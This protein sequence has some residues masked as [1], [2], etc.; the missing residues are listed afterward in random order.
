MLQNFINKYFRHNSK[1]FKNYLA[2]LSG[3]ILFLAFAPISFYPLAIIANTVLF[4]LW[5]VALNKKDALRYGWLFGCGLFSFGA[6]WIY[7]SLHTYGFMPVPIALI[8]T[9]LFIGFLALFPALQ[10]ILYFKILDI[11]RKYLLKP[12]LQHSLIVNKLSDIKLDILNVFILFPF[13]YVFFEWLRSWLFTGFPW[14]FLGYS[15]IDS[16]LRGFAPIGSVYLVSY[17][18]ALIAGLLY[19]AINKFQKNKMLF[20]TTIFVI[21]CLFY[22]G[23]KLS[24]I[25]WTQKNYAQAIQVSLIQ[26]NIPQEDKWSPSSLDMILD[27][28]LHD[29]QTN[30]HSNLI[31]LPEAGIPTFAEIIPDFMQKIQQIACENN[32]TILTGIPVR[33][34][35]QVNQAIDY[36]NG[37]LVMNKCN[38]QQQ[39]FKRHLVPFGEYTPLPWLYKYLMRYVDIP[40]S[41][42]QSGNK[43]QLPLTIQIN[44]H[45]VIIAPFICYEISYLNLMLDFLPQSNILLTISDDSWFG[46]SVAS[47]QHLEIARMRSLE[48]G[49]YQIIATNTGITAVIDD[50]GKIQQILPEFTHQTLAANIYSMSGSTPLVKIFSII[51]KQ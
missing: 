38:I 39:Y 25:Q 44:G 15:Q 33:K 26:G 1:N 21:V 46:K 40:M 11:L 51:H 32:L 16:P 27:Q 20:S 48:S 6:S 31:V 34:E 13:I 24:S 12:S 18:V 41:N 19:F 47:Q 8:A 28:Y 30:H 4:Y 29:I 35:N 14:L 49:R 50:K 7:V 10:G 5:N 9:T 2:I 45:N 37:L 36:Y 43:N 42:F 17:M 22:G 23:E 3:I